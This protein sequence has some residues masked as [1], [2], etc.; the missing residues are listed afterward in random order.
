MW[1][2]IEKITGW[3]VEVKQASFDSLWG[4]MDTCRT[5]VVANCM[6][7]KSERLEKYIASRPYY[8][9]EQVIVIRDQEKIK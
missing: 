2:E 9:D 3:K 1:K 6:G 5:D 4:E 7:E 8:V